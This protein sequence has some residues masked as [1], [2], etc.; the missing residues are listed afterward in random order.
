MVN[1]Y[2]PLLA[3]LFLMTYGCST[4]SAIR[5]GGTNY[6]YLLLRIRKK[7]SKRG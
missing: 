1:K 5:I 6:L 3:V 2:L 7:L 4:G